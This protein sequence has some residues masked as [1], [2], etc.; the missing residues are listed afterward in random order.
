MNKVSLIIPTLNRYHDV[1]IALNNFLLLKTLQLETI[2]VDQSE[3]V[4]TKVLCKESK[5]KKLRIK[6]FHCKKK[7]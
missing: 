3:D 5:Y 4:Q 6:Y 1:E 2:I 7:S